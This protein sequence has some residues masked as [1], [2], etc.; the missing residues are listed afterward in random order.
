MTTLAIMVARVIDDLVRPDLEPQIRESIATAISVY[1]KERFRFSDSIPLTVPTFNTVIG[2][3]IYTATDNPVIASMMKIDYVAAMIGGMLQTLTPVT[4]EEIRVYNQQGTMRGQPMY[5]AYE[6]NS[7]LIGPTPSA[8]YQI[9]LDACRSV[10]APASDSEIGNP[11]MTDGE[12][13]IRSRAKYEIALNIT[14]NKQM[15]QDFSP[16]PPNGEPGHATWYAWKSLKGEGNRVT[17]RGRVR[18]MAW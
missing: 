17:A 8:V 12:L 1:Q 13:L 18:A 16:L 14:R 2:Q 15:Q 9:T 10:P 7:L 6:G 5:W 3:W 11:W 4:P